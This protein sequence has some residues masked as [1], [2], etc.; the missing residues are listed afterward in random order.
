MRIPRPLALTM[1]PLCCAAV[2]VLS[3][4]PNPPEIEIRIALLDKIEHGFA[5]MALGFLGT[6]FFERPGA[7]IRRAAIIALAAGLVFGVAI[8]FIQPLVG[9]SCEL[10]DALVDFAGLVI[11]CAV[12]LLYSRFRFDS[13]KRSYRSL[14]V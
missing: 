1:Y 5:Y 14:G 11:G 10:T 3:L 9:R 2:A 13:G 12:F 4:I 7:P 6:L 8:E